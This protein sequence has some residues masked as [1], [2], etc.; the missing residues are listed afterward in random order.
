MAEVRWSLD[1]H[2]EYLNDDV[3]YDEDDDLDD[4]EQHF[5]LSM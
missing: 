2:S 4:D 3:D 1:W 5:G